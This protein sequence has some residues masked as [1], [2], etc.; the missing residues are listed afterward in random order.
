MLGQI[1]SA[2]APLTVAGV[3]T[4]V[5]LGGYRWLRSVSGAIGKLTEVSEQLGRVTEAQA[6][7][8]RQ[9]RH[10]RRELTVHVRE[11]DH[12][13]AADRAARF[14]GPDRRRLP[15]PRAVDPALEVSVGH[16]G[17]RDEL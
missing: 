15:R 3:V 14:A 7:L 5:V 10:T 2:A 8:S 11:C 6:E 13:A 16:K 9:I 17:T 12:Q 1:L 4:P